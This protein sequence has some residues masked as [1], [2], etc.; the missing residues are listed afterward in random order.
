MACRIH[1]CG[2]IYQPPKFRKKKR[3]YS[4]IITQSE[5]SD[6]ILDQIESRF[7]GQRYPR[8]TRSEFGKKHTISQ[9]RLSDKDFID[10]LVAIGLTNRKTYTLDVSKWFDSLSYENQCHFIRGCFDGDGSLNLY[11]RPTG[12]TKSCTCHICSASEPF[13]RMIERFF[14]GFGGVLKER[15][16]EENK[17]AT[18]SLWYYYLNSKKSLALKPIY[19][20][21]P[22]L[23]LVMKRKWKK[24]KE[25]QNYYENIHQPRKQCSA[26]LGAQ[27]SPGV[28]KWTA[29]IIHKGTKYILGYYPTEKDAGIARDIAAVFFNK[30]NRPVNFP[31]QLATY[32][33]IVATLTDKDIQYNKMPVI[34]SKMP[35]CS[36]KHKKYKPPNRT[37]RYN[38]V[39]LLKKI[40]RWKVTVYSGGE[41]YPSKGSFQSEEEAA[42]IWDRA[43]LFLKG[44]K[45]VKRLNFPE[46][47]NYTKMELKKC[48]Q[49][50]FTK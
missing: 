38:G 8:Y 40:N 19:D 16:K 24:F 3:C 45:V 36:P 27:R 5:K 35:H 47:K 43:S 6:E 42:K 21:N 46:S 10:F 14:D 41:S 4:C 9:H 7:G 50:H 29:A 23:N 17:I 22:S 1:L 37:S 49:K 11:N 25:I 15:T 44:E 34:V 18:C 20:I 48:F 31:D 28:K 26:I 33:E 13:I 12:K 2:W 39:F 32:K 30:T